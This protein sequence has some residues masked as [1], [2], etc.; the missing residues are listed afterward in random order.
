MGLESFKYIICDNQKR[1]THSFDT[2]YSYEE[3]KD[4]E[5]LAIKL[6][7]PY[8]I[9]DLDNDEEFEILLKIVNALL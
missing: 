4:K 1:P 2:T 3:V 6:E 9:I 5:N 8:V 7:E